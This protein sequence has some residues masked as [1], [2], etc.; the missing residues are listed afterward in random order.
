[1]RRAPA[2][3]IAIV[4]AAITVT[5]TGIAAASAQPSASASHRGTEHFTFM[6]TSRTGVGSVIATG[7]FTDGGTMNLF[8]EGPSSE[9]KL[10][11]G[12]IR[13]TPNGHPSSK[14]DLATCLT[15]I[16]ERGTYKL[17]RGTGRYAGIRGSGHFTATDHTLSRRNHNG[18]CIT[19]RPPLALQVIITFS[20]SATLRH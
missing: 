5:G 15:T 13:V 11:A 17:S 3:L 14:S 18:G 2:K 9:V 20:G 19:D 16:S 4:L 12:T 10:G 1:M 8:G 7:L 6:L